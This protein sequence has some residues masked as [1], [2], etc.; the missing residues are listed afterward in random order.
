MKNSLLVVRKHEKNTFIIRWDKFCKQFVSGQ[1]NGSLV[2]KMKSLIILMCKLVKQ[3]ISIHSDKNII[4]I[5][6]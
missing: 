6:M 2:H 1:A 3:G 4:L 5:D